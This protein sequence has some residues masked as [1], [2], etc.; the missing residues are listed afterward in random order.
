MKYEKLVSQQLGIPPLKNRIDLKVP[1]IAGQNYISRQQMG[2]PLPAEAVYTNPTD[3]N[4]Q[5]Q[6]I[7]SVP[8]KMGGSLSHSRSSK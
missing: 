5:Q 1:A 6:S 8:R 7:Y 3:K 2:A 4:R